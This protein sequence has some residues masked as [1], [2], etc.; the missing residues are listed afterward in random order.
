MKQR[1]LKK[2]IDIFKVKLDEI[3]CLNVKLGKRYI[4][5]LMLLEK[6]NIFESKRIKFDFQFPNLP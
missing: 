6:S 1:K 4:I 5:P 3:V 2:Q